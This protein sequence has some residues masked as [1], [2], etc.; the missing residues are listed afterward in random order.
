[1]VVVPQTAVSF[2]PYGNSVYVVVEAPKEVAEAKPAM[3]GMPVATHVVKQRFVT[4]GPTRGDLVGITD[5]LQAGDVVVTSGLLRLRND[6]GVTINNKVQP[7]AQ[8]K[9]EPENR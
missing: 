4:T 9:P 8:D 3:E 5:G 2:N 6:A 7:A 1:V